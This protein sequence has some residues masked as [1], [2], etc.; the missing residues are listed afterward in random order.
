MG[1]RRGRIM[2]TMLTGGCAAIAPAQSARQ[3]PGAAESISFELQSWGSP[4]EGFS[5]AGDGSGEF[6]K[7]PEFRAAVQT[8]RFNAGRAGF[9]RIRA[10][11]AAV[12]HYASAEVPCGNRMTDFPYGEIV[13]QRGTH[14]AAV[15]L[16]VGCRSPEMQAVVERAQQATTL[17]EGYA[18]THPAR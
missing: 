4:M 15:R 18:R 17:A 12:E 3:H 14:R 6:H 1:K 10:A 7:A 11:L 13:W 2:A 5:I 16:D 8:S 9:A